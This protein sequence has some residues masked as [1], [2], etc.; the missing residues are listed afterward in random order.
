MSQNVK[1]NFASASSSNLGQTS[2]VLVIPSGVTSML[3]TLGGT[4]D[5]SNTAKTQK[6]TNSGQ[7]WVDQRGRDRRRRRAVARGDRDAAAV[8]AAA[9]RHE[10]RV[11]MAQYQPLPDAAYAR[12]FDE[13]KEGQQILEEL[14]LRFARPAKLEGGIDAVLQTYH[15]D[16]ARSVI[17]WIVNRI[18]RANGVPASEDQPE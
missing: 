7:T 18:N 12:V 11:L 5:A 2:D 4:I 17:E 14:T 1:G 8:E 6:S 10:R 15:R 9:L 3:L 13:F 16:G